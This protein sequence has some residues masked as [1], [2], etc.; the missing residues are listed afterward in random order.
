ME[1]FSAQIQ[2]FGLVLGRLTPMFLA[3]NLSPF[4]R[5]PNLVRLVVLVVLA[6]TIFLQLK[7]GQSVENYPL[8][9]ISL[10]HELV[11][12]LLMLV[13]VQFSYAAIMMAG[14]VL[15]MQ[16]GFAAAGIVDPN[17]NNNDPLMGYI[18]ALFLS[19]AMFIS[20]THL[21]LIQALKLSFDLIP[22]GQWH[23]HI[24]IAVITAF[25]GAQIVLAFL[26]LSPVMI[27]LW[28]MDMFNGLISKSMPQ[29][30]VYF[31][32]LPLKIMAGLFLFGTTL[33]YVKPHIAGIFSEM[34]NWFQGGFAS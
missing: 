19:V 1:N 26:V 18:F 20:N 33:P 17:T 7:I 28:L 8:F 25:L 9:S 14:R 4:A 3:V 22:P 15:D 27:G 5:F 24:D 16:I 6:L 32:M 34:L 30:N 10:M 23:G 13:G 21:E 2:Q 29:M 11:L 12:G 31:V